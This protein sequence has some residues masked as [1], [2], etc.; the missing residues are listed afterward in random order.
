MSFG[1]QPAR[2]KQGC[3]R[4]AML[5]PPH[6]ASIAR[7]RRPSVGAFALLAVCTWLPGAQ[8]QTPLQK[9]EPANNHA[10]DWLGWSVALGAD[11]ALVGA[12]FMVSGAGQGAVYVYE[13]AP[14]G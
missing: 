9:L 7:A 4:D 11:T 14:G 5:L 1:A 10:G 13:R 2:S 12:P 3:Y 8:A 6:R